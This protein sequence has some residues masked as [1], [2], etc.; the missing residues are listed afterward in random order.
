MNCKN[1]NNKYEGNFCGYCGQRSRVEKINFD[2]LINEFSESVFQVNYGMVFTIKELCS[3]PGHSIREYLHGKRKNH[4]RPIA[5][6]F[7]W[8]TVYFLLSGLIEKHTFLVEAINGFSDG[9]AKTNQDF[10]KVTNTFKWMTSNHA[11]TTLLFLPLYSFASYIAFLGLKYNY[12]EH[13]VLNSYITGQQAI[14]YAVFIGI[15][16][17]LGI[18]DYYFPL[19]FFIASVGFAF[20]TFF[21]FFDKEKWIEIVFRVILVYFLYYIL[22]SAA[23]VMF[24]MG[25]FIFSK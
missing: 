19:L 4:F 20:W 25:I 10:S 23:A 24:I 5:F 9:F 11:Y 14:I 1:C 22:L 16:Y 21:Q 13:F 8:S 15:Q 17:V 3:R 18:G 6:L 12:F 2:Y 7:L